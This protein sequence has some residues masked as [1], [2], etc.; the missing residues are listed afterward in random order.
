MDTGA[1]Q[2]LGSE[3]AVRVRPLL[4]RRLAGSAESS[5]QYSRYALATV[6]SRTAWP[7][8]EWPKMPPWLRLVEPVQ[9]SFAVSEP[10]A[11]RSQRTMNLLCAMTAFV[12]LI[13]VA[14]SRFA[15]LIAS[16]FAWPCASLSW[17]TIRTSAPAARAAAK[18][19]STVGSV[20]SYTEA[21]MARP[22]EASRVMNAIIAS[23]SPRESHVRASARLAGGRPSGAAP[24]RVA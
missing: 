15:C 9:S 12:R 8:L 5:V 7:T 16:S 17:K 4:E 24:N 23:C 18:A 21:R 14:G 11:A 1:S 3:R 2:V 19:A 10:S 6:V 13:S 22:G 20:N